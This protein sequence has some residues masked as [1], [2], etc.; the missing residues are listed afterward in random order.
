MRK[1]EII[2]FP[3][4]D[5]ALLR[6]PCICPIMYFKCDVVNKDHRGARWL[7]DLR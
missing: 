6:V 2:L 3:G 7:F 1:N 4:T 5:Y